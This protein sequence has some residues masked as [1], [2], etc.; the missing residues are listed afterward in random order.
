MQRVMLWRKI[1]LTGNG[2]V[3]GNGNANGNSETLM[4]S[5]RSFGSNNANYVATLTTTT[6]SSSGDDTDECGMKASKP[7]YLLL[8]PKANETKQK[9]EEKKPLAAGRGQ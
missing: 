5:R 3:N 1:T 6:T 4:G 2:N 7:Q 8:P 9:N